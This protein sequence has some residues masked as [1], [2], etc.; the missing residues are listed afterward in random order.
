MQQNTQSLWEDSYKNGENLL[1]YPHNE[2]VRF[3]NRFIKKQIS[4]DSFENIYSNKEREREIRAL[5]FGC[6]SGR[7]TLLLSQF[8]IEAYGIDI[9]QTAINNAESLANTLK[10][11]AKFLTNTSDKIPFEDNFFDFSISCGVLNCMPFSLSM[12][13]LNELA[14]V[15]K[16]YCFLILNGKSSNEIS[17]TLKNGDI[18]NPLVFKSNK[19]NI[20]KM[21]QNSPF[22]LKWGEAIEHK[23]LLNN[24]KSIYYAL[25]LEKA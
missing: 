4:L 1:F 24:S 5:D 21:L 23:N 9:S 3:L 10:L 20:N 19:N 22:T 18:F 14:R 8:D 16:K 2:L 17:Y 15:S 25:V 6:G 7:Q 12:H 11:K 13:Y